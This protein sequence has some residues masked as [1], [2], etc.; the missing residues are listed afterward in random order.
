MGEKVNI[1]TF[2]TVT[3]TLVVGSDGST[4]R[5][6]SSAG[7][8]SAADRSEFLARRPFL[9]EEIQHAPSLTT[10]L[11]CQLLLFPALSLIR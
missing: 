6:G 11:Q 5:N 7:V 3:V 1:L 10:E 9:S 8:T 4:S 2:M